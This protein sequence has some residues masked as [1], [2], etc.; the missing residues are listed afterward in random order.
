MFDGCVYSDPYRPRP[1]ALR[2][3]AARAAPS[4]EHRPDGAV[5]ASMPD[6]T[7][8]PHE[9]D[10]DTGV[11]L[12]VIETP[13]GRRGKFDYDPDR[14]AFRLKSLLP[15]GMSFPLD[16]GFIPSTLCDDGDP[17]DV[18]VLGD[19]PTSVGAL[20]DVRLV[21]VIRA[22]EKEKGDTERN[23]RLLAVAVVSRLYEAVRTPDDLP[24]TFI[25]HLVD[26]WIQKDRLEGKSFKCLGVSGPTD[27]IARVKAATRTK[28][29]SDH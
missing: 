13:K 6:L 18:M 15:E 17:L 29:K 25:E 9:L 12:A 20:L 5:E 19:E 28:K 21:G 2:H 11:C 24:K 26:F 10:R 3:R 14:R 7:V 1:P 4:A 23:D 22:E 27:A 16:F 8:L